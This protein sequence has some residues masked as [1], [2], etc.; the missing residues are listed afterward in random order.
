MSLYKNIIGF[1]ENM[2]EDITDIYNGTKV[3]GFS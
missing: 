1:A 2:G 3:I